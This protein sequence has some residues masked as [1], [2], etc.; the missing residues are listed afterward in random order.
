MVIKLVKHVLRWS[1]WA[2]N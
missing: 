2:L 1:E